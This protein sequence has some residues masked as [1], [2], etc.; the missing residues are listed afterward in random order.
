MVG[1]LTEIGTD[2]GSRRAFWLI[3]YERGAGLPARTEVTPSKLPPLATRGG[4]PGVCSR[5]MPG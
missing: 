3:T 5:S 1:S 4:A 2:R